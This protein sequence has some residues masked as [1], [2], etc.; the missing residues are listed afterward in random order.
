MAFDLI[1]IRESGPVAGALLEATASTVRYRPQGGGEVRE[2]PAWRV[3]HVAFGD[4]PA[5]LDAAAAALSDGRL[6]DAQAGFEAVAAS[7][8]RAAPWARFHA[9]NVRR[10]RAGVAAVTGGSP[11]GFAA[12][13]E[14]LRGYL[15]A[16]P[17]GYH[18]PAALVAL[19]RTVP[20]AEAP[21]V[22]AELAE[23]AYG[24]VWALHG[25]L[26]LADAAAQAGEGL[27]ALEAVE[28][29]ARETPLA[30]EVVHY[31]QAYRVD[32]LDALGRPEEALAAVPFVDVDGRPLNA[33]YSAEWLDSPAAPVLLNA[34]G[35]VV[36]GLSP[37]AAGAAAAAPL[38]QR[39]VRYYP[40]FH[41]DHARAL[42]ALGAVYRALGREEYAAEMRGLLAEQYPDAGPARAA[43]PDGPLGE[44]R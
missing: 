31:A 7:D 21:A 40:D 17:D 13:A 28:R 18:R 3:A 27:E 29:K 33:A 9:A 1:T 8:H 43:G 20:A 14:A 32:A 37:D 36:I 42:Y 30:R 10:I 5:E 24:P 16:D 12:A 4:A 11:A 2:V 39:I 35:R 38:H 23:G 25:E 34:V 6:S 15:E 19:G 44:G 26:G 41:V 22:Y